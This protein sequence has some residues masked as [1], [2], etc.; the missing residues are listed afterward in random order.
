M[1]VIPMKGKPAP[2]QAPFK[3]CAGC[4]TAKA[5]A[6]AGKCMKRGGGY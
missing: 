6:K 5:C 4:K 1:K 2:K 3:P